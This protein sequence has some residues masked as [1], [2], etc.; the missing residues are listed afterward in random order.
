VID[1]K[2][3]NFY[4]APKQTVGFRAQ[5]LYFSWLTKSEREQEKEAIMVD[6]IECLG[7][8]IKTLADKFRVTVSETD[9][10]LLPV[11]SLDSRDL[12][13]HKEYL[14]KNQKSAT[15]E[16]KTKEVEHLRLLNRYK[17]FLSSESLTNK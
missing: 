8:D 13:R 7:T 17:G 2:R 3:E 1:P 9:K 5:S 10:T 12:E 14:R 16:E 6:L 15:L 4:S 11:C